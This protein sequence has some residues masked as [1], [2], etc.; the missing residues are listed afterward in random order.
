VDFVPFVVV[1]SAD[2]R[3]AGTVLSSSIKKFI[4][5]RTHVGF[6]LTIVGYIVT[7]KQDTP[8]CENVE[9]RSEA[10]ST[11]PANQ[12]SIF[13]S[14]FVGLGSIHETVNF[15]IRCFQ[16]LQKPKSAAGEQIG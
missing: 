3:F 7:L 2:N 4:W 13:N 5:G 16:A 1:K 9:W 8:P 11:P 14:G 6:R 10:T 12:S 15:F